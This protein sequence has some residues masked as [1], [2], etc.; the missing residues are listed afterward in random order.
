MLETYW[1]TGRPCAGKT[2]LSNALERELKVRRYDVGTLDGDD[3]RT[4][5]CSDL[6]FSEEGRIENLRRIAEVAKLFNKHGTIILASFVSPTNKLRN[7]VRGIIGDKMR[8]IYI[9]SSL[10][11]CE[12]R[13]VKGMYKLA[14]EGKIQNFTGIGA[15]F[16]EP[17]NP[18]LMLD[19]ER[20][21][22]RQCLEQFY[23]QF[24]FTSS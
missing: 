9:N 7:Y 20:N 3:I 22:V 11:V 4:G 16:E 17:E 15:P 2:T 13:D 21:N 8:L 24:G 6:G 19:T 5:L 18:D 14:R 12:K 1:F 10:S 23:N